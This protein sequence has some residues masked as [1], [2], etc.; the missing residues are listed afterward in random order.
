MSDKRQREL[1]GSSQ[2]IKALQNQ[3]RRVAASD[4]KVLITGD[5]GVG[6]ELVAQALH[7]NGPRASQRFIPV[8]CAGLPETLLESELFGHVKGS[9]T[10]AFRDQAGKLELAHLGTVFL[11]ELGEMTP[12]MLEQT[13]GRAVRCHLYDPTIVDRPGLDVLQHHG[14]DRGKTGGQMPEREANA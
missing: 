13:P 7:T 10:G 2:Q 12:R 14:K 1:I 9:F 6:K 4:A 8:N 11:D 3:V 5:S